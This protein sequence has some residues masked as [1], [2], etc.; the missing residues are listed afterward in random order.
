MGVEIFQ[1]ESDMVICWGRSYSAEEILREGREWMWIFGMDASR[2]EN[3][4]C[5]ILF[6]ILFLEMP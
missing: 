3:Q 1:E 5:T 2:I 4:T 6:E